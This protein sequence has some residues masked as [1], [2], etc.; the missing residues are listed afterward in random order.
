MVAGVVLNFVLAICIYK[1]IAFHW[2]DDVV[3]F[4]AVTEGM[5]FSEERVA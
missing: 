3:P 5:D 1:G 4:Q 2:G